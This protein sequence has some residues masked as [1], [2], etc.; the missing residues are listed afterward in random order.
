MTWTT[1]AT[2][3]PLVLLGYQILIDWVDLFP[4]NDV[5]LKSTKVR[6]LEVFGNYPPL[7]LSAFLFHLGHRTA[8][9]VGLAIPL[10]ITVMHLHAWWRPYFFGASEAELVTYR[11]NFGRTLKVLPAIGENP[12]PDAEHMVVGLLFLVCVATG[13]MAVAASF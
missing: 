3:S 1:A 10:L 2:L 12:V 11:E 9:M 5:S 4:W 8:L 7:L 6:L 13:L